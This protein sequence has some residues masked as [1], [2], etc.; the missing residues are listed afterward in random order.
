MKDK[1]L[2]FN[3]LARL[4]LVLYSYGIDHKIFDSKYTNWH[5]LILDNQNIQNYTSN[6]WTAVQKRRKH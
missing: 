1:N 6:C 5:I 3:G 4:P 2:L